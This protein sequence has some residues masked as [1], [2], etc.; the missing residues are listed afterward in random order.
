L[1]RSY[2]GRSAVGFVVV[3]ARH[4]DSGESSS[5]ASR[6]P[7]RAMADLLANYFTV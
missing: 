5:E 6:P 2:S 1:R 4:C 7:A 3:I